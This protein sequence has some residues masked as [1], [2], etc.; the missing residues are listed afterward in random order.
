MKNNH[1]ARRLAGLGLP[2]SQGT[3]VLTRLCLV[4]VGLLFAFLTG[5][6]GQDRLPPSAVEL[7]ADY[8]VN[9]LGLDRL[10]PALSWRMEAPGHAGAAQSAYRLVSASTE[11]NLLAGKNAWDS[12]RVACDRS[13]QMPYA[14]PK[15][16][17][18][19]RVWW[20]VK[21]WDET[22]REGAWSAPAWFEAGLLDEAGW[23]GAAWIGGTQEYLATEPVPA[24][25]MGPWIAAK[26]DSSPISGFFLDV[27]LPNKPVVSAMMYGGV[28]PK[29]GRGYIVANYDQL[30]PYYKK[31]MDRATRRADGFVDMAFHLF[32][33]K[34]NRI[35]LRLDDP[36]AKVAAAIGI[37]IVFADG[38]EKLIHSDAH[39][40]TLGK[41]KQPGPVQVVEPYGGP[42]NGVVRQFEQTNV[43]P[44][45]FRHGVTAK[46]G[47][48]RARLY[49]C[50][51]G[52]GLVYVDGKPVDRVFYSSP[53]SDYEEFAYYT[54]N[55]ITGFLKAGENALAVL[56]DGGWY[57]QVGAF[58]SV[59]SYGRPGLKAMVRLDYADGTSEQVLSG[60]DWQWKEGAIRSSNVYRGE[61]VDF[62]KEQEEWK[63]T[64]SGSGWQAAQVIPPCTPKTVARDVNPVR[65]DGEITPV[66]SWQIGSQ[67]WIFDL[68]AVMHGVVRL[69]F[70]EPAGKT[71]RFRY[72]EYVEDGGTMMNVPASNWQCHGVPQMDEVIAD[73]KARVYE[74]LFDT[75][76]FRFVEVSGLSQA[77]QPGD[78]IALPV[79]TQAE[80]LTT[81]SSSDP[82]LNRLY[83]NGIRTFQNYVNNVTGDIPR[84]RCLWGAES[85]YSIHPATYCFD[86]AP[87]HRLMNTLWWTGT[88]TK[89]GIPGQI[90]VGKRLTNMTQSFIWSA[91]PLFLTS[92]IACFYGDNE[93]TKTYYDK[94]LHFVRF[95]E[96]TAQEGGIPVPNKLADH[97]AVKSDRQKQD[98]A[99]INAMFFFD[100][101]NR[102]AAMADSLGKTA[103]A[104]H[105]R[106]Y[107]SKIRSAVMKRYDQAKHTFGNGTQD[108]LALAYGLITDP[109]EEKAVAASLVGYYRANGHQFDGGFMSYEIYP[110][111]S[112]YGYV[113]DAYQMLVNPNYPGP[114]WSV[115]TYDATTFYELYTDNK[116]EQMKVGQDF[117]AFGHPTSWMITD[118]A[119]LRYTREAPNGKRMLLTPQ[120]PRSGKLSQVTA[121]LK[122]PMGVVKS[123]WTY[124]NEV[125]AWSFTIPANTSAEVHLPADAATAI[126]G[127]EAMKKIRTESEAVIYEAGAGTYTVQSRISNRQPEGNAAPVKDAKN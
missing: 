74:S 35:E 21:V 23:R 83:E 49:L 61:R 10:P 42:K 30:N 52:A 44:T 78:L 85:V 121:S 80:V 28:G 46:K 24:E 117:F 76:S 64:G 36:T 12:G 65:C 16:K 27:D 34:K 75:K 109:A 11:A 20:R 111:L 41:G 123:A 87:N 84:E 19:E 124:K 26:D 77:P 13:T 25:L 14:G 116:D 106:E 99:L 58:G 29:M 15:L 103:D 56:L 91:T 66:K 38:T 71:V 55:D 108:S 100:I 72:S 82:M 5:A 62:R 125:F 31:G 40:Q 45:W 90:G 4:A 120:V 97:A 18:G 98:S 3:S 2:Y 81:F 126:Q 92:E 57:H 7:R 60:S 127:A 89:D 115:K 6:Q 102:F 107:A 8:R 105:A 37:R 59:F 88:M 39:W 94:A 70:N 53:Q 50:A 51:L 73:G 104:A 112:K 79:H 114:A 43:P 67:T 63:Q 95:F 86:W 96:K 68:G 69:K 1:S 93:P 17:A 9:P 48:V 119:G 118:L 110:M 113:E 101:Q 32:P 22:G 54:V 122:T 47:L 33:G